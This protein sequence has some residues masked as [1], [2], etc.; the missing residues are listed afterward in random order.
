MSKDTHGKSNES[1][2]RVGLWDNESTKLQPDAPL[3]DSW[4]LE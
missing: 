1:K 2:G 4:K 3:L